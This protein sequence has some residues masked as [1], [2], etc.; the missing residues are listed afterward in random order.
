MIVIMRNVSQRL[1][2]LTLQTL[3]DLLQ[4]LERREKIDQGIVALRTLLREWE[5]KEDN[6]ELY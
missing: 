4:N 3:R 1:V 5:T 2:K 6:K